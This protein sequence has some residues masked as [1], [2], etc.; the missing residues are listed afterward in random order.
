MPRAGEY[1]NLSI[2]I[3]HN[4]LQLNNPRLEAEGVLINNVE[5]KSTF[6][7]VIPAE[8]GIQSYSLLTKADGTWMPAFAGM[9]ILR[10]A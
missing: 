5:W 2:R 9:T 1:A 6:F 4:K 10:F 8:A 3:L 7:S